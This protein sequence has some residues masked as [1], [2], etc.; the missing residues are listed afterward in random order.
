MMPPTHT[1]AWVSR[2]EGIRS[3]SRSNQRPSDSALLSWG[4]VRPTPYPWLCGFGCYSLH[5]KT[6]GQTREEC[7][8]RGGIAHSLSH[9]LRSLRTTTRWGTATTRDQGTRRWPPQNRSSGLWYQSLAPKVWGRLHPGISDTRSE[10]RFTS[11]EGAGLWY[12]EIWSRRPASA[13]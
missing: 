7:Q 6:L 1:G 8:R 13:S 10:T 5:Y 2:P 12:F 11:V 9:T 3:L 4:L